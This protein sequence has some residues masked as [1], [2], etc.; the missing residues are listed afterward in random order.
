MRSLDLEFSASQSAHFSLRASF[1]RVRALTGTGALYLRGDGFDVPIGAGQS[2]RLPAP[3]A[4]WNLEERAG[5]P[6]S[7]ELVVGGDGEEYEDSSV[8]GSVTVLQAAQP[9]P[10]YESQAAT[11]VN[12]GAVAVGTAAVLLAAADSARKGLRFSVAGSQTIYIGGAGVTTA[13]GIPL[14]VGDLWIESDAAPAAW[15]AIAGAAGG[16]VIVQAVS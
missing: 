10:V 9:L 4:E 3:V 16:S 6:V 14:A 12:A 7:V 15:Y 11:V 5:A 1:F 8:S 2:L 13:N